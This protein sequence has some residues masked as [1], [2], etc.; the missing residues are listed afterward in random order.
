MLPGTK[1]RGV[2][3]VNVPS[4]RG[5]PG[6]PDPPFK[7]RDARTV[8]TCSGWVSKHLIKSKLKFEPHYTMI[9]VEKYVQFFSFFLFYL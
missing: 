2:A 5:D 9:Y 1:D 4:D 6:R 7:E 3:R 8:S